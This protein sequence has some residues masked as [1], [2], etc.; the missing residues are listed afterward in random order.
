MKLRV[1]YEIPEDQHERVRLQAKLSEL[2]SLL[3][4]VEPWKRTVTLIDDSPLP[5]CATEMKRRHPE[6]ICGSC[7]EPISED[8]WWAYH[9]R[10]SSYVHAEPPCWT[11]LYGEDVSGHTMLFGQGVPK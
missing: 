10:L 1:E 7:R 6:P 2:D 8:D 5:A 4:W 11:N 3:S 9:Q